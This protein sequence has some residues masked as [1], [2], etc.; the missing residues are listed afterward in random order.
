[1]RVQE[2]ADLQ[3]VVDP[4]ILVPRKYFGC[5]KNFKVRNKVWEEGRRKRN[6]YR[7]QIHATQVLR[8]CRDF[9]IISKT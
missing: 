3:K 7:V 9:N 1:M 6:V 2:E 5:K 4:E 8:P